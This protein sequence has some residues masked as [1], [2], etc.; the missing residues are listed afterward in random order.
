MAASCLRVGRQGAVAQLELDSPAN[1]NA[2]SEVLVRE[3][4]EAL[5]GALADPAVRVVVIGHRGPAFSSGADLKEQA[6]AF[7]GGD[8]G[9][10]VAG[11]VPLFQLMLAA[12]KPLVCRVGG[13]ARAGGVGLVAACDL[14]VGSE[15]ADFATG[16]VRL[17]V[18]PAVLSVVVLPKIGLAAATRLFLTGA[19]IGAQE[20]RRVGLLTEVVP[21]HQLESALQ[22]LLEQLLLAE[23]AALAA[24]KGILRRVPR[25]EPEQAFA[26]MA[27]LSARL[28]ASPGAQ[29]GMLAFLER[30]SPAWAAPP[31]APPGGDGPGQPQPGRPPS[32]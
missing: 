16:E 6:A 1:R 29:E 27:E 15:S 9:P 14:A 13:P 17:G 26:E 10:G 19:V 18:A 3:L 21:D 31:G 4:I 12:D 11:L 20:A 8:P 25:L 7:R 2:L 28:F 24:A 30:R 22:R 23:P 32:T 5:A